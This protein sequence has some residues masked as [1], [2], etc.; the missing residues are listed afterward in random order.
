MVL[1]E[2]VDA[3][4]LETTGDI[5]VLHGTGSMERDLLVGVRNTQPSGGPQ[6]DR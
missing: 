5:S 2:D 3:V 6:G 4:V 1:D